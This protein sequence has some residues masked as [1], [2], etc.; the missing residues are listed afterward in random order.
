MRTFP[1][2]R[3]SIHP[4]P[5]MIFLLKTFIFLFLAGW[6]WLGLWMVLSYQRLFGYHPDDPAE[7]PGARSFNVTQVAIV[8]VGVFAMAVYFLFS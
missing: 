6:C 4:Y 2:Q 3:L 5:S 1:L 7:S 8:W